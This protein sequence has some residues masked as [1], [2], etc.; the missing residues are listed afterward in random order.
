MQEDSAVGTFGSARF[1]CYAA[2]AR[3]DMKICYKG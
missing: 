1:G 3:S 2:A